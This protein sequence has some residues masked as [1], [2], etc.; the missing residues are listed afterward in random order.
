MNK[1]FTLP[2]SNTTL[3]VIMIDNEP[4]FEATP[5]SRIL[6]YRDAANMLR[7]VKPEM[8]KKYSSSNAEQ[9]L[10]NESGLYRV[11]MKSHKPE[12]AKFQDWVTGEVLPS[13]RKTGSY[14]IA[15]LSQMQMISAMALEAHELEERQKAMEKEQEKHKDRLKAIEAKQQVIDRVVHE[16]TVM[17]YFVYANLGNINLKTANS[18]GRKVS[19][20]CKQEGFPIGRQPDPRFGKVNAYPEHALITILKQEGHIPE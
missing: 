19:K 1:Q 15:P 2:N 10:I 12:A 8:I 11:I 13:I 14:G 16:F 18:L 7:G 6:G 17:A 9:K 20:Y 3:N 5:V 4:W